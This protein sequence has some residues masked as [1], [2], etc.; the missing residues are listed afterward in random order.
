MHDQEGLH[1]QDGDAGDSSVEMPNML[2]TILAQETDAGGPA[3]EGLRGPQPRCGSPFVGYPAQA[4]PLALSFAQ[5]PTIHS[6]PGRNSCPTVSVPKD[7]NEFAS[8]FAHMQLHNI[9][10]GKT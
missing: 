6:V 1:D 10:L 9:L 7:P 2:P 8:S 5:G 3:I 4:A